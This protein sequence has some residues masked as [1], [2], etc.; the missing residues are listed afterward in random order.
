MFLSVAKQFSLL[1]WTLLSSNR[2]KPPKRFLIESPLPLSPDSASHP[3]PW[4]PKSH[5]RISEP[6]PWQSFK[7]THCIQF[8]AVYSS[9]HV[10][11]LVL[12]FTAAAVITAI[13]A[14][15]RE[16]YKLAIC[17]WLNETVHI[18]ITNIVPD[19][20]GLQIQWVAV[21]AL[22]PVVHCMP[23]LIPDVMAKTQF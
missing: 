3:W 8:T 23:L 5:E 18:A 6:K 17:L 19:S 15:S 7:K 4:H 9:I 20:L 21:L 11:T 2:S 22:F 10:F 13:T 16:F 14:R 12:G 1:I